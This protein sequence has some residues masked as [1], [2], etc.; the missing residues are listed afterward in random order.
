MESIEKLRNLPTFSKV[1]VDGE[2]TP[3][4]MLMVYATKEQILEITDAIEAEIAE[5][6]MLLP[7]DAD[8]VPIR[9]GDVVAA[10]DEQPFEVRAFQL[11]AFGWFAIERLGS[12]WNVNQLHHVK[13]RTLEDVLCD[14]LSDVSCMGD[15]V[16]RHFD[17]EESYVQDL[18]DE[19]RKILGVGE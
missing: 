2:L 7:V 3:T 14:A 4:K 16:V 18:A 9:V 13:P 1:K 6:Y 15:G 12:H 19:I 17:Q 11:D 10:Q 8:G 5:K